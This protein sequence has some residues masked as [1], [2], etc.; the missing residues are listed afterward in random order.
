M[1]NKRIKGITIE[2]DGNT[3]KLDKALQPVNSEI[4]QTQSQLKDVERLLKLDPSNV[5]LLR[6]KQRLL[7]QAVQDTKKKLDQLK[8]AEKQVQEQFK[9]GEISRQ[10]YDA[11][12]REIA[13][14]EQALEGLE[15]KAG[16]ANVALQKIGQAGEAIKDLGGKISGAGQALLPVT[17]A[18]TGAAAGAVKG[19]DDLKSAVNTYL[20]ATGECADGTEEAAQV[21]QQ[22]E[23]IL[24]GIYENN[25]GESLEDV[26]QAAADVRKNMRNI[27]TDQLQEATET[28]ITLRDVFGYEVAEST[29]AA[30]T[31]MEQ[32]GISV[33]EAFNLIAQGAQNGLDYSGELIDSINEYSVQFKKVGLSAEDMFNIFATGADNGAFNLDKIGDA[34]KELSIR[35]VDGSDTTKE[36]FKA[37]GLSADDMAERFA[38]GGETAREAFKETVRALKDMEDPLERNIAGV[39]LFGTMW[40]DLGADV[41]LSMGDAQ[42][43]IDAATDAVKDLKKQKYDDL[44]NQMASVGRTIMTDIAVPLGQQ[45]VPIIQKAV[46]KIAELVKAFSQLSPQAQQIILIVGLLAAALGPLLI[47]IGQISTGVGALMTALSGIGPILTALSGPGGGILLTVAAVGALS[48]AF[49]GLEMEARSYYNQAKELNE[50]EQSHRDAVERLQNTYEQMSQRR[51]AAAESAELQAAKEK[52]LADELR[53]IT[54]ENG[55]VKAGYEER[56]AVITGQLAQALGTEIEMTGNQIQN[57][58]ELMNSIDQLILKKKAEAILSANESDYAEAK[59]QQTDATVAYYNALADVQEAQEALNEAEAEQSRIRAEIKELQDS[60]KDGDNVAAA[61][62][63]ELSTESV[64]AA[65]TV[66]GYAEKMQALQGILSEAE[67]AWNQYNAAVANYENLETA[68]SEGNAQKIEEAISNLTQ[69]FLTA[70]TATRESLERQVQTYEEK[71]AELQR[72]IEAGAP[73]VVEKQAA[74]I[75][76]MVERSKEELSKL[77]ADDII[78]SNDGYRSAGSEAA[79]GYAAGISEGTDEV[80]AAAGDVANAGVEAAREAL[81]SHSPS[82]VMKGVGNDSVSGYTGGMLEKVPEAKEAGAEVAEASL[83]GI[84][85]LIPQARIWGSDMMSGYVQGIRSRIKDIESASQSVA[86]TVYNYLHFSR[87]EKGPLA[88]Y[89]TWMPDMMKGLASGILANIPQVETAASQTAEKI[90]ETLAAGVADSIRQNKKYVKKTE[91]EICDAILDAAQDKLDNFEVYNELTLAYEVDFW[92]AVRKQVTEGTQAR[93]DADEKYFQAKKDLNDKMEDAEQEYTENVAKA[94]EDLNDK[95]QDLNQEY[96]DAVDSRTDEI[97]NAF[98]LFDEFSTDT[99]LTGDDLLNNLQ[100]QVD[101]LEEWRDNLDE[102]ADRGVGEDLL[103]E[104]QELGPKSAAQIKLLTQMTDDELSQYTN[105]YRQKNRIARRQALEELEPMQADITSQIEELKRQTASELEDYKNEYVNAMESLGMALSQPVE[106]MKLAMAQGAVEMVATM[107]SSVQTEAGK[108]ENTEKFKALADGVLN[109]TGTLPGDLQSVGQNSIAG[110]IVG[111]Q[112]QAPAL[113][114]TVQQIAQNVTRTMEE[115]FDIHSPSGV[116]E[117]RISKNLM[118]GIREGIKKYQGLAVSAMDLVRGF[119]G[120]LP[121]TSAASSGQ[122]GQSAFMTE[123]VSILNAYLPEIAKQKYVMLDS[124]AVVGRTA[125]QMDRQLAA[126]QLLRERT[127]G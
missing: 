78:G 81:D 45:L 21:A 25:Y 113:Y 49:V 124:K 116:M 59:K 82:R 66:S 123:L 2:I 11:L 88:D 1:A 44:K 20:T 99:D 109:A 100:S 79:A 19:A 22:F 64:N 13:A 53:S 92:D 111:L 3:T 71:Y 121:E 18:V 43:S 46:T 86:R 103:A 70:E 39:N 26:A 84:K 17:A 107:A 27:P 33:D 55:R 58:Q 119:T 60:M 67:A 15:E 97:R 75:K 98:G 32:F 57:Y 31:L 101:G 105:L 52:E 90:G 108:A 73:G 61:Q 91:E 77:T 93:I 51:E 83:D 95:I 62:M 80:K 122:A 16:N 50:E 104:L 76:E 94:Y 37:A 5:E 34:I 63:R 72:A 127:T 30:N 102:L 65:A 69:N 14:T 56:A 10:Q 38:A 28:A 7:T 115:A 6:Q 114:A 89:E 9:R 36:G 87:P 85:S 125:T 118:L 42:K 41:V 48:A 40:E 23:E 47:I 117:E 24:K 120:N 74:Q 12:Q 4:S 29:R 106:T 96:R 35:V 126:N 8:S 68:L 54:D 110:M 112:G